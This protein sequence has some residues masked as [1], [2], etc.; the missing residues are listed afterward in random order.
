MGG[1]IG[2]VVHGQA[3]G[4]CL[5]PRGRGNLVPTPLHLQ[6][7]V[8][9]PAWAGEPW[10]GPQWQGGDSVYP[11][12]GGGTTPVERTRLH[13]PCL[14]PRGRG[15][16]QSRQATWWV[17]LSIPA[18]AGEPPALLV[19]PP[20]RDVYPRLC[21]GTCKGAGWGWLSCCLSPPMRGNLRPAAGCI[22][23]ILSIPAYAGEPGC[24][25]RHHRLDYVY[26]RLCGGTTPA[27]WGMTNSMCLSPPMRG[28]RS[29]QSGRRFSAVSIP[30]YAGE[31]LLLFKGIIYFTRELYS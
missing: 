28:N 15:N 4:E 7:E 8:S 17:V 5:S 21:G 18:Y 20:P 14:S 6:P 13:Y 24:P 27:D 23:G 29:H 10:P 22:T 19:R 1:G 16:L 30:A 26:P 12:V 25:R 3:Q 11:R 2:R 9:I 31:P